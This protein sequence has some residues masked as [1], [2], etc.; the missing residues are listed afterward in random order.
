MSRTKALISAVAFAAALATPAWTVPLALTG[1]D[2]SAESV[3]AGSSQAETS[4]HDDQAAGGHGE[5]GA[6]RT[7]STVVDAQ[8][9]NGMVPGPLMHVNVGDKVRIVVQNT[10]PESTVVHW[11][12]LPVPNSMDGVADVTQ[13]PIKPGESF[14]YS[15]TATRE[16]VGWYHS[17]HN[18]TKQ[19]GDG[20]FGTFLIGDVPVPRGVEVAQEI[21]MVLQDADAIGLSLNGKSFPATEPIRARKGEWLKLHY[22]NAGTQAHPMHLHGLD[23]LVIAKD[24]FPLPQP[25]K[26]DTVLVAPGER[27][28]VLIKADQPGTWAFHCHIFPHS[29]GAQGMFGMFTELIVT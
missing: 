13:D 15:F 11:H 1:G 19:V 25:Y 24:G 9:Y 23:Q 22:F 2:T 14:T 20:L 26:A 7:G 4:G 17:H 8:T 29:E 5:A 21:P 18:G 6:A 28:T 3:A 16:S 27:Y 12:G 10:L